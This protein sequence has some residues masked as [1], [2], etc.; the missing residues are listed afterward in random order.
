MRRLI[1]FLCIFLC[2]CLLGG[3]GAVTA[4][5]ICL[6][7]YAVAAEASPPH[8]PDLRGQGIPPTL[9]A[10]DPADRV[11][12][13]GE[14]HP[15]RGGYVAP[16][17][18]SLYLSYPE[19]PDTLI[20]AFIAIED[21]RFFQ[22]DG[23]DLIRL[24]RAGLSYLTRRGRAPGGSTLTQQLIKNMT[25]RDEY[26]L[27]RK[28]SELFGALALEETADK[29]E[30]LEAYLNIINL[31]EGCRGVGAA[32]AYYFSKSVSELT[33]TECAA[34]AAIPQNPSRY[35]PL[36]HPEENR[37]RRELVLS[38]MQA[39]GYIT[40]AQRAEASA[41]E[42][43]PDPA[44]TGDT[45]RVTGW[46]ADMVTSDVIRDLQTELGYSYAEAAALYYSGGLTVYTTMDESL[47]ELVEDHYA[48]ISH[49]PTGRLGRPQSSLILLDPRT[50]DI[51]AVAG[52]VG[53]KTASRVQNYATDTR[54]PAGSA[55]KPLSVFAPAI[56]R[57]ILTPASLYEDAPLTEKRGMPWPRNADGLYRG[58]VTA[59][60][61]LAY[62]LNP[63][64]VELLEKVG[65]ME[66][67]SFLRDSLHMDSLI[68]AAKGAAGDT[69][70]SSLAMGQQVR[71]I[72]VRELTAGYTVL[73]DGVYHA[74]I[75]Y[76]KVLDREGRVLL[77]NQ[78]GG[79]ICLREE[80]AALMTA[81]LEEVVTR[82]T[83]SSLTLPQQGIA[84]AGKTGTTQ[85]TCDRWF[86]GYTPRLLCGVW[87][88]YDFPSSLSDLGSNPCVRIF[89]DVMTQAEELY[90][91]APSQTDFDHP[92]GLC[93]ISYCPLC[94]QLPTPACASEG[95]IVTG[96]FERGRMPTEVCTC[97]DPDPDDALIAEP[98]ESTTE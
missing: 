47:Q 9:Y 2:V 42:L 38:Q 22:H 21:K 65:V 79:E 90:T 73:T 30:I 34:L 96:W 78:V 1:R 43:R 5:T 61:A 4:L 63:V 33:L 56:Q 15:A 18:K 76:R 68:P 7:R 20:R 48:D 11:D 39:Q 57:G 8:I 6:S 12:A 26:T 13:R 83:A 45:G 58:R 24:G 17:Q 91:G 36:T 92:G 16:A 81:M 29:T 89:D 37:A 27:E 3:C 77:E 88:G 54:R 95:H 19:L 69:T 71:G 14:G 35:D 94:G 87:M 50:G 49:F 67:F 40:E 60:D 32:A 70:L 93:R 10:Y 97:H 23:I 64:A 62:S 98:T 82:G 41:T 55:I 51:L 25:G 74:P 53:E 28:F 66:S 75:S 46:F 86:V 80:T 59:A 84:V 72:T 31:G 44:E 52:A 85:D